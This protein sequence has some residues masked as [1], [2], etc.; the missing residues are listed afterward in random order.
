MRLLQREELLQERQLSRGGFELAVS[1]QITRCFVAEKELRQG[2]LSK[3]DGTAR[4]R[5][6]YAESVALPREGEMADIGANI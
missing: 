5:V 3:A 1:L 6:L 2:R 4:F